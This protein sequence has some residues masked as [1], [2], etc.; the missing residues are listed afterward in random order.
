MSED[1]CDWSTHTF[2]C[3]EVCDCCGSCRNMFTKFP[4]PADN[5]P[6]F[7][8]DPDH[9]EVSLSRWGNHSPHAGV[10]WVAM[11]LPRAARKAPEHSSQCAGC[12]GRSGVNTMSSLGQV[13]VLYFSLTCWIKLLFCALLQRLPYLRHLQCRDLRLPSLLL[14]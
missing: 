7:C 4:S 3:V 2:L 6:C 13:V 1:L 10:S 11:K 5:L 12:Q 14:H 9:S 8:L